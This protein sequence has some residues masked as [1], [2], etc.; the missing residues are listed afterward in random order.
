[1]SLSHAGHLLYNVIQY[2]AVYNLDTN[3]NLFKRD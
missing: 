1:M 3:N 2:I